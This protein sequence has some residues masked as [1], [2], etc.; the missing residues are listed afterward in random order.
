MVGDQHLEN[1]V[2][3]NDSVSELEISEVKEGGNAEKQFV[4]WQHA[5]FE[6]EDSSGNS[7]EDGEG[8]RQLYMKK[9]QKAEALKESSI[10]LSIADQILKVPDKGPS[11][12]SSLMLKSVEEK[13]SVK[14]QICKWWTGGKRPA[15]VEEARCNKL[16]RLLKGGQ[17]DGEGCRKKSKQFGTEDQL[18]DRVAREW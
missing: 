14:N 4:R 7:E 2:D 17:V 6:E 13:D 15:Q 5:D 9:M 3:V 16:A 1:E 11:K 12:Y 18:I 10:D 8:S